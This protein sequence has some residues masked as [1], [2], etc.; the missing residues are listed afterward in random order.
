MRQRK[1]L[2]RAWHRGTREMDFVLG[3]FVD[4]FLAEL[5]EPNLSAMEAL[6]DVPD[7]TLFTWVTGNAAPEPAYDTPVLRAVVTLHED[8]PDAARAVMAAGRP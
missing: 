5:N 7:Q 3:R 1:I 6:L 4:A 8:G 2:Y